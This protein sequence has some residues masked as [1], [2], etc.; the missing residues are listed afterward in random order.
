MY[1][2]AGIGLLGVALVW[3]TPPIRS[4]KDDEVVVTA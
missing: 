2:G 3:L 1:W 4:K